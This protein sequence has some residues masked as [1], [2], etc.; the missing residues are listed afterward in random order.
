MP[1]IGI[2]L[3]SARDFVSSYDD[4]AGTPE[5]TVFRIGTLDSRIFGLIRDK[6][7][8]MQVDPSRPSDEVQTQ[9]NANEVA[10]MAVQYGLRG[11][12]NFR[13][14]GG[15][16]IP[17]KTIKRYHAGQSYTVVDPS[18]LMRLPSVVLTELADEIR[19]D[20]E[21]TEVEAKN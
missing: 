17:F 15:N 14:S 8:T 1:I 10:F 16:D 19:K 5:A 3:D 21:I 2:T 18:I 11:W 20:N 13:D 4:A 9:I 7:T 6:S 12:K